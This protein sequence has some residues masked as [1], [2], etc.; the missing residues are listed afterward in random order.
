MEVLSADDDLFR[1][2]YSIPSNIPKQNTVLLEWTINA[3]H[4]KS[5]KH[6][7]SGGSFLIGSFPIVVLQL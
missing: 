3:C 5:L 7:F 1:V 4:D 6:N 2:G